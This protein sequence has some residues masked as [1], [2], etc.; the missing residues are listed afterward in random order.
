MFCYRGS[1][2]FLLAFCACVSRGG[3]GRVRFRT[4]PS[5]KKKITDPLLLINDGPYNKKSQ[6]SLRR[7]S[8][9]KKYYLFQES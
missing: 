2:F 9:F 4:S 7:L 1:E 5:V 8:F 6:G 3:G